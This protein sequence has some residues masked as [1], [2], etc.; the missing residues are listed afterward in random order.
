MS[1][2]RLSAL[3]VAH[4][5]EAQIAACL[6]TL[7]FADEIRSADDFELPREARANAR[8]V[9]MALKLVKEMSE[10]WKP[11]KYHDTYRD[12][13]LA[14]IRK[15]VKA[16]E[17]EEVAE[18]ETDGKEPKKSAQVIDLMAL[19]K[20]SVEKEGGKARKRPAR[21]RGARRTA[22]HRATHERRKRA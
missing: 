3:V 12:D 7:R 13:L 19:L 9:Q 11:E 15:K 1:A 10:K 20:R 22:H 17:T 18:P 21:G 4:N 2:A 14:R 6:D 8:E 5:E 16:G